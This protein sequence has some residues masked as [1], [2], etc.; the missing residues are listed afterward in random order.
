MTEPWVASGTLY[1]AGPMTGL[2]EFNYPAFI[3]AHMSLTSAGFK[4]LNPARHGFDPS[5]TW[6]DYMRLGLT[7]VTK[8]D[9]VAVLDGWHN[10]SG[11]RL[12]VYVARRLGLPIRSVAAWIERAA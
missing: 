2:P 1:V 5:K 12:E 10:S 4:V 11:A 6:S 3:D 8:C 7:D 9:G